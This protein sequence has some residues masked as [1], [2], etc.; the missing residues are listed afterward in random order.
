[1]YVYASIVKCPDVAKS[2]MMAKGRLVM[3]RTEEKR[4]GGEKRSWLGLGFRR[5]SASQ[6]IMM[7]CMS[8]DLYCPDS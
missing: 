7:L 1:V 5:V 3:G 6:A 8:T 4:I 2:L